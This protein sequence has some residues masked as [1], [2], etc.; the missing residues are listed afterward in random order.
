MQMKSDL[1]R[2][3]LG[4]KWVN[5][6]HRKELWR[7]APAQL[8]K[9]FLSAKIFSEDVDDVVH[10]LSS[11]VDWPVPG[12][13]S[14]DLFPAYYDSGPRLREC[15]AR[16]V[17]DFDLNV[18]VETGVAH[19]RL[20]RVVLDAFTASAQSGRRRVL[21]SVDVDPRTRHSDLEN[22][23]DWI[24]HLIDDATSFE[25]IF[26]S[27]GMCDLFIHDSDHSYDN[28]FREYMVAWE[29]LRVGGFLVSDDV[30]WSNA[31]I[32]FCGVKKL[33][34]VLLSDTTKI[35]GILRKRTD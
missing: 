21:H 1:A 16:L 26:A 9:L 17:C 5:E 25:S 15:V 23:A 20:T 33:E 11:D 29:R 3:L 35:S 22:R 34:P 7:S 28:Q 14:G 4:L 6:L 2:A 12:K 10:A 18:V 13:A 32:D 19:G 24:F 31:F 8:H 27:I 30:N